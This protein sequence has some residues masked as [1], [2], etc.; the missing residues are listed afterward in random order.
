LGDFLRIAKIGPKD[1]RELAKEGFW[2]RRKPPYYFPR[3]LFLIKTPLP[4]GGKKAPPRKEPFFFGLRVIN[5]T[6]K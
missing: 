2:G 6:P 5:K 3:E 1:P 4:N